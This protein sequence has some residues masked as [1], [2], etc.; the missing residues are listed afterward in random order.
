MVHHRVILEGC[1]AI[2]TREEAYANEPT[3]TTQ[4]VVRVG[5]GITYYDRVLV[6]KSGYQ[7]DKVHHVS[8]L[9]NQM[10]HVDR[11]LQCLYLGIHCRYILLGLFAFIPGLAG[12][13]SGHL[14][15]SDKLEYQ[16]HA[17]RWVYHT[18]GQLGSIFFVPT[19]VQNR[20]YGLE[21]GSDY[22]IVREGGPGCITWAPWKPVTAL[23]ID[24][25][26]QIL[27]KPVG[28]RSDSITVTWHESER[29]FVAE[30]GHGIELLLPSPCSE[31]H[32][33]QSGCTNKDA[34]KILSLPDSHSLGAPVDALWFSEG[35]CVI[36]TYD[37]YVICI[38]LTRILAR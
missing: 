17:V 25:G 38:E 13:W 23:S 26:K 15:A 28:K 31:L 34:V 4:V 24:T 29:S 21:S 8:L 20:V 10:E 27:E 2:E 9:S 37:G 22:V 12:C 18:G 3:H 6:H 36:G 30:I 14:I 1:Q 5:M 33:R 19:F 35:L 32:I 11:L 16:H 7:R